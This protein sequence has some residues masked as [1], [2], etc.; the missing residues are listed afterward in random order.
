MYYLIVLLLAYFSLQSSATID[1]RAPIFG[2][3]A[4]HARP[5]HHKFAQNTNKSYG[6]SERENF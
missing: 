3:P 6:V 4:R 1:I 5:V 2:V